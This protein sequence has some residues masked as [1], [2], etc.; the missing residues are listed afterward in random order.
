[1]PVV[2]V[3]PTEPKAFDRLGERR[4]I[5]ERF[6]VDFWWVAL[7][8][9]WGVQ[10]KEI[11]DLIASVGDGRLSKELGQMNRLDHRV[12]IVEGR[13]QWSA[14]GEMIGDG[15]GRPWNYDAWLGLLAGVMARGVWVWQTGSIHE[16]IH[17]IEALEKWSKKV[18]HQSLLGREPISSS[19]GRPTNR[20]FG[21]YMLT[22]L[23]GVG[24]E[25]AGRIW[26]AAGGQLPW[27]WTMDEGEL[28]AIEGVGDK[29]ARAMIRALQAQ[30]E[31]W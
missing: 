1:M 16:T 17:A 21:V 28:K 26:E 27:Q 20:E 23:P 19:W 4:L 18:K 11:K 8:Q 14:D 15:W 31:G 25:I 3:A 29:R 13:V 6:G 30:G 7:G 22:G 10:R 24:P 2:I 5:P 9:H 12:L